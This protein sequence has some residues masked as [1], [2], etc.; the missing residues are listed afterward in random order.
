VTNFKA[1]AKRLFANRFDRLASGLPDAIN[2]RLMYMK[3]HHRWPSLKNPKRFSEH[4]QYRKL[5]DDNPL[6]VVCAD[7]VAAKQYVREKI[8]ND[9]LIPTL[10]VGNQLPAVRDWPIPF[11]IKAS[12]GSGMNIVVRSSD[13]LHWQNIEA[14]LARFLA[15][16]FGNVS[17]ERF[18]SKIPRRILVEPFLSEDGKFPLDYKLFVF[19]G[20]TEMIQLDTDREKVH[21]RSFYSLRWERLN[22]QCGYPQESRKFD[23]PKSLDT[24]IST[25]A[26]L[27]KDFPFVRIDFYDIAGKAYFGEMTFTPE[28]GYTKLSPLS[29]DIRLGEMWK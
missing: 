23:A 6:F 21:K 3:Y 7:K 16:D 9:I 28:S 18:Y 11:V 2:V 4:I 1:K 20:R 15:C 17:R 5:Y 22:I 27:G 24:M 10:Y 19:A 8:G 29:E 26:I 14:K 25:A 12:H 13:S